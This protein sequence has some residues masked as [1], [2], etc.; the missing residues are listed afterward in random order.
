MKKGLWCS[1]S[2]RTEYLDVAPHMVL[3]TKSKVHQLRSLGHG[4]S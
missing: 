3:S 1:D 4:W 2:V